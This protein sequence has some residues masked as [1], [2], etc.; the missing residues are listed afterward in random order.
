RREIDGDGDCSAD[1]QIVVVLYPEHRHVENEIAERAAADAG[2]ARQEQEADDIE[3][4]ARSRKRAGRGENRDAGIVEEDDLI[5]RGLPLR[6]LAE[7]VRV[8]KV[9]IPLRAP[10]GMRWCVLRGFPS[11]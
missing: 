4:L 8:W 11:T 10:R 5:H 9:T 2:H 1:Q 3:L 7:E 6:S